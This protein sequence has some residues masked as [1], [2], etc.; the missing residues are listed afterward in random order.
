MERL[1]KVIAS[2]GVVSRRKAEDMIVAGRVKVDGEII[3]TLGY[4]VKKDSRIEI[5]NKAITK[6]EKVYYVINKPH[7]CI[8]SAK[9]EKGRQTVVDLID[10]NARIYPIG[11]LDY[12]T[13]GVL[14]LTNDG[15]FTNTLIHPKYH[16]EKEYD[17]TIKG[18]LKRNDLLKL[19]HG[20]V[21]DNKKTL[22]AK[23]EMIARDKQKNMC[24]IRLT[25]T[26]G[27]NHQVK[28]MIKA[29][30][31]EV[32]KLNRRRFGCITIKGLNLGEYRKL[33]PF[34]IKQLK[35]LAN[36]GNFEILQ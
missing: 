6:E 31:F 30:G 14:L 8:S 2:Y 5:D 9:D 10:T 18:I 17:V 19:M 1:Q 26:E 4:K 24:D 7:K 25:I 21:I 34:E 28:N 22:P 35:K 36:R 15:E 13:T 33:K 23:V 27:R 3:Q 11:R 16:V 32:T 20:I 12:D 29:L